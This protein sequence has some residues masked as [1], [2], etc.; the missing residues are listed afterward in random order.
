M[1][2]AMAMKTP[3]G[4][5]DGRP[6]AGADW[7][8]WHAHA[9]DWAMTEER[10]GTNVE[11]AYRAVTRAVSVRGRQLARRSHPRSVRDRQAWLVARLD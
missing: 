3:S 8:R 10:F 6:V 1:L 5:S 2:A 7:P 4:T 11:A 9:D